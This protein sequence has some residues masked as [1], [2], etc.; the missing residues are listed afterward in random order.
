MTGRK[1]TSKDE[2]KVFS[3]LR[4]LTIFEGRNP[5]ISTAMLGWELLDGISNPPVIRSSVLYWFPCCV[6]EAQYFVFWD[7]NPIC[8]RCK[9]HPM[10]KLM[11]SF[12]V[13]LGHLSYTSS[14]TSLM[15]Y[16]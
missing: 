5:K 12:G 13:T 4:M 3:Y 11:S 16:G 9:G 7:T 10:F 6:S 2:I 15:Q 1:G 8:A 14:L